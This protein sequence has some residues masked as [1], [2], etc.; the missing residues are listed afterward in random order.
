[1]RRAVMLAAAACICAGAMAQNPPRVRLLC[2]GELPAQ[3]QGVKGLVGGISGLAYDGQRGTWI[4]V[5]DVKRGACFVELRL[6]LGPALTMEVPARPTLHVEVVRVFGHPALERGSPTDAEAIAIAPDGME[7]FVGFEQPPSV[8]RLEPANGEAK[9]IPIERSFIERVRPNRA[10]E[11]VAL[12][13]TDA[14]PELWIA[15]ENALT[16]EPVATRTEGQRCSVLVFDPPSLALRR[17]S[18]YITEPLARGETAA[19]AFVAL[20]DLAA[21]P[22]GRVLALEKNWST[23][24]GPGAR[25]FCLSGQERAVDADA[26]AA[27]ALI[28]FPIGDLRELGAAPTGT[29]E[30]MAIGPV[31]AKGSAES[32][33]VLIED[34]NFGPGRG[35]QVIVLALT[36]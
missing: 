20:T 32:M 26:R 14:G 15:T 31:I 19:Q 18:V 23:K 24:Y 27:Q 1:M 35:S 30:A 29:I 7:W 12:R 5:S 17:E 22:D 8:L 33:L 28:K 21:M 6:T 36:P 11:S 9:T 25:I 4:A 10:F 13:P 16:P 3:A 2:E 34:N